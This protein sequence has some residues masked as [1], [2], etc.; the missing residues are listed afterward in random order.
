MVFA[1]DGYHGASL[2]EIAR[3]AG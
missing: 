1:E 3:R 2:E